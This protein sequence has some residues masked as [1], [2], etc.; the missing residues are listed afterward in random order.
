MNYFRVWLDRICG[1][2]QR[3]GGSA[4]SADDERSG[5]TASSWARVRAPQRHRDLA[6]SDKA[7]RWLERLPDK[8]RP[9]ELCQRFPRIVNR[10]AALWHD[11]GLTEYTFIG[12]LGD[13]RG[14]RQGF[15]PKIIEELMALYE[16]HLMRID[17]HPREADT[18]L[19]ASGNGPDANPLAEPR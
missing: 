12:L 10:I 5:W 18:C 1:A 3:R 17:A 4:S 16:L 14:E 11:E 19:D 8:M 2:W 9:A 15:P 13:L 7:T 6:L